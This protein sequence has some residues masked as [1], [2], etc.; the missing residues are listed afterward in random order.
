MENDRSMTD[1][2]TYYTT[3]WLSFSAEALVFSFSDLLGGSTLL[4][5]SLA[6]A[7]FSAI[8][9]ASYFVGLPAFL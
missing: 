9:L 7:F 8:F 2:Q 1:V 5:I 3:S 4:S 6:F